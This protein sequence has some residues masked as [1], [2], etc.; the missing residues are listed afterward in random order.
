MLCKTSECCTWFKVRYITSKW[1]I[2]NLHGLSCLTLPL[3]CVH[4]LSC[5]THYPWPVHLKFTWFKLPKNTSECCKWLKLPFITYGGSAWLKLPYITPE[6][7]TRF[8]RP[9]I[10]TMKGVRVLGRIKLPC[11]TS[12]RCTLY[13]HYTVH[14]TRITTE[15]YTWFWLSCIISECC[16]WFKLVHMA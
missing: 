15:E 16:K 14:C 3:N 5:R 8:K 1:C 4:G 6:W 2:Q 9:S 10:T 7:C 13:M 11:F 12:E